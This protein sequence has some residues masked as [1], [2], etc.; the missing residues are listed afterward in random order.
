MTPVPNRDAP[1][2][3]LRQ[4][5]VLGTTEDT[6]TVLADGQRSVVPYAT[7]FRGPRTERVAPGQLVAIATTAEAGETVVWRW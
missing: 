5:I 1:A 4:A 2:G 3:R 6:C 7:A